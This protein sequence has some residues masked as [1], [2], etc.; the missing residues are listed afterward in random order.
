MLPSSSV[1]A[2][3]TLKPELTV[4]VLGGWTVNE[5]RVAV[6]AAAARLGSSRGGVAQS[7]EI[8]TKPPSRGPAD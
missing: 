6:T 2:T 4:T 7:L 8:E 1:A 3:C 5:N